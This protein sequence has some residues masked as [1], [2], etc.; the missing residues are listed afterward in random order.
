MH[1]SFDPQVWRL[2]LSCNGSDVRVGEVSLRVESCRR[3]V[4]FYLD[5]QGE[6]VCQSLCPP[7]RIFPVLVT[8]IVAAH[9]T[10]DRAV[11]HVDAT[12]PLHCAIGDVAF[13]GNE[14][15]GA[16]MMDVTVVD[17]SGHRRTVHAEIPSQVTVTGTVALALRTVRQPATAVTSVRPDRLSTTPARPGGLPLGGG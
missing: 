15:A 6:P 4:A 14:L 13:P 17:A 12:L 8:R 11:L 5:D 7:D 16:R 9:I 1:K 10:A 3:K 2:A